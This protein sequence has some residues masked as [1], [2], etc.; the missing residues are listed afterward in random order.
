MAHIQARDTFFINADKISVEG[1]HVKDGEIDFETLGNKKIRF[2]QPL[3][4]D[5]ANGAYIQ[6]KKGQQLIKDETGNAVMEIKSDG[7]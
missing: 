6:G 1:K 7:A 5:N 3:D 4:I 2:N